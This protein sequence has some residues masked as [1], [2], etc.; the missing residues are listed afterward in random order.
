MAPDSHTVV[1]SQPVV[2]RAR[3]CN[4]CS[5]CCIMGPADGCLDSGPR[6]SQGQA[7]SRNDEHGGGYQKAAR[8]TAIIGLLSS[9]GRADCWRGERSGFLI[10]GLLWAILSHGPQWPFESLG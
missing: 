8:S 9:M 6:S 3:I 10:L 4:K 7:L 2:R 5:R 1:T